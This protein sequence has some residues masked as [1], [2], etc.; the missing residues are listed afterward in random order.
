MG[1]VGWFLALLYQFIQIM[2]GEEIC[3]ETGQHAP[4]RE[5]QRT[6][7]GQRAHTFEYVGQTASFSALIWVN[8]GC[9][10]RSEVKD[11]KAHVSA[12]SRSQ[13]PESEKN[14]RG[15]QT[16]LT[17]VRDVQQHISGGGFSDLQPVV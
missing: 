15:L 9:T 2:Q 11:R 12:L 6:T 16:S 13:L 14:N 5:P 7:L 4:R 10:L 1:I 3:T 17:R 8:I